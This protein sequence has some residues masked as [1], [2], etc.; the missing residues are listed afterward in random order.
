MTAPTLWN[1]VCSVKERAYQDELLVGVLKFFKLLLP[2]LFRLKSGRKPTKKG[3]RDLN[4]A[5]TVLNDIE[6]EVGLLC[7]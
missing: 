5:I 6:G 7:Q 1:H 2:V 4:V 3:L